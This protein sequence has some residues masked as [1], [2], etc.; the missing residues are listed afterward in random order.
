MAEAVFITSAMPLQ[1][2]LD[3]RNFVFDIPLYQRPYQWTHVQTT[4]LLRDLHYGYKEQQRKPNSSYP[5]LLGNL[6]LLHQNSND[7]RAAAEC[8]T[9]RWWSDTVHFCDVI[10]GQQRL[11]TLCILYA[12]LQHELLQ[13]DGILEQERANQLRKRFV[14]NSRLLQTANPKFSKWFGMII[15]GPSKGL[16]DLL[17]EKNRIADG[18]TERTN[19]RL[20]LKWLK[21]A[22]FGDKHLMG[23][24][25]FLDYLDQH[26]FLTM[27]L[28]AKMDLAFR[29]FT[30]LNYSGEASC[31]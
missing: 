26:V 5:V 28:T 17:E 9:P 2:L 10:D 23:L 13:H 22:E 14:A 1:Q 25:G 20:I 19:A 30:S 12:A 15:K 21:S 11:T 18:S 24:Q 3:V 29:T 6:V 16:H 27:T 4:Q 8:S 7:F 31:V